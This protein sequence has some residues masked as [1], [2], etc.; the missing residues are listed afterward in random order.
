MKRLLLTALLLLT[1]AT[2]N[3][4]TFSERNKALVR[5]HLDK[6]RRVVFTKHHN[7]AGSHYAY[8]EKLSDHLFKDKWRDAGFVPG[9]V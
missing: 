2:V 5:P 8:T 7:Q 3:A 9:G 4:Q 1:A 6:I